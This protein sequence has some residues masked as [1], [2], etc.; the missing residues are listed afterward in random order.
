[1][2]LPPALSLMQR[3]S[4]AP[5][6]AKWKA[7]VNATAMLLAVVRVSKVAR[8]VAPSAPSTPGVKCDLEEATGRE[9]DQA[10]AGQRVIEASTDV[11]KGPF[12]TYRDFAFPSIKRGRIGGPDTKTPNPG[13]LKEVLTYMP[14][15]AGLAALSRRK[16]SLLAKA[17]ALDEQSE[18]C[19]ADVHSSH[20][21]RRLISTAAL[22]ALL[23]WLRNGLRSEVP[24]VSVKRSQEAMLGLVGGED[25]QRLLNSCKRFVREWN[26]VRLACLSI[27]SHLLLYASRK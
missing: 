22:D 8:R 11:Q 2:R 7:I 17:R 4:S 26:E 10:V 20:G 3:G 25:H 13:P 14:S 5:W 18:A 23:F 16:G 12:T 27:C 21:D 1:V 6:T 15:D 9:L 24:S 19:S